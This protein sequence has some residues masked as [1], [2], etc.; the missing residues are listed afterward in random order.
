M[1]R[2]SLSGGVRAKGSDRIQFDFE[3]GDVRYRPEC[4]ISQ[5]RPT[6]FPELGTIL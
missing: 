4:A 5:L 2:K 1:G 3:F 6:R